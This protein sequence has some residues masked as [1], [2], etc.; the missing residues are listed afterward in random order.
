MKELDTIFVRNLRA[1]LKNRNMK[2]SHIEDEI[3]HMRG[4]FAD[5]K[6]KGRC[7]SLE[8]ALKISKLLDVS[9]EDLCNADFYKKVEL[10]TINR[11]IKEL[12]EKRRLL[13]ASDIE[14]LEEKK[15]ALFTD[16]AI[17]AESI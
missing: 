1:I 16:T 13:F 6:A 5:S 15:R 8:T 10:E 4:Y 2:I 12:E 9:V 3:H 17:I 11:D 7:I 14:K